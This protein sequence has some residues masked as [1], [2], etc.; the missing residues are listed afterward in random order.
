M[1]S[2]RKAFKHEWN[3]KLIPRSNAIEDPAQR[4]HTNPARWSCGCPHFVNSRFLICKHILFFY[5]PISDPVRFFR[6]VRRQRSPPFWVD[7]QLVLKPEYASIQNATDQQPESASLDDDFDAEEDEEG[8]IDPEG[9]DEDNL[10]SDSE[11]EVIEHS[12]NDPDESEDD[13]IR[14]FVSN[15]GKY[16][17]IIN[18]QYAMGNRKFIKKV[19]TQAGS[20]G[21]EALVEDYS[22]L[23]HQNTMPRTWQRRKNPASMYLIGS[24]NHTDPT[25]NS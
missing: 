9:I 14:K 16:A 18:D 10:V 8:S 11:G 17:E 6:E 25:D 13:E 21:M 15:V 2:W 12:V 20:K 23:E 22:T 19:M 7:S 24:R 3:K 5:E 4:Y 1:A